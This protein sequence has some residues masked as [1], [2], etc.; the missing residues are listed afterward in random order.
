[1]WGRGGHHRR[2]A[3]EVATAMGTTERADFISQS[4]QVAHRCGHQ[5]VRAHFVEL[6]WMC[7]WSFC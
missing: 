1:M 2:Q 7:L 3:A 5:E 6:P 4:P